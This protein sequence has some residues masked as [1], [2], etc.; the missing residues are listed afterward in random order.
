[1]HLR[2]NAVL[3]MVYRVCLADE[4]SFKMLVIIQL[5]HVKRVLWVS[6]RTELQALHAT[7]ACVVMVNP[8]SDVHQHH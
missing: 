2:V 1:M 3:L 5:V 6:I 4:E 7:N 8:L